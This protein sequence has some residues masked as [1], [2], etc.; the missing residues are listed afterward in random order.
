[1]H[2]EN[3]VNGK[4]EICT[5]HVLWLFVSFWKVGQSV[6]Y[7]STYYIFGL[8][9]PLENCHFTNAGYHLFYFVFWNYLTF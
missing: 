8:V 1:M 3:F 5:V 6:M 7:C 2:K 4:S 9:L